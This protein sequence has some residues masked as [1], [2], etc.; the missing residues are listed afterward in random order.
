M[1]FP[2]PV[3]SGSIPISFVGMAVVEN[4]VAVEIVLLSHRKVEI[5]LRGKLHPS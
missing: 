1:D 3:K 2:F 5:C 4:G